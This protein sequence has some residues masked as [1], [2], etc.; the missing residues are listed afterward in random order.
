MGMTKPRGSEPVYRQPVIIVSANAFNESNI[1]T[2]IAVI[3]TSYFRLAEAPGNIILANAK[4]VLSLDSVVN[5]SQIVTLDKSFLTE[6][7]S[8]LSS[9]QLNLLDVGIQLV[10]GV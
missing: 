4:S 9:K 3:I 7:I 6:K 10:L 5:V 2:I 8:R 1:Q